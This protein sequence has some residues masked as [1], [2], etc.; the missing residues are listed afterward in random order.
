MKTF[1]DENYKGYEFH[2]RNWNASVGYKHECVAVKDDKEI[3]DTRVVINW[4]NRTWEP[5]QYASVLESCKD[6]LQSILDGHVKPEIDHDFLNKLADHCY[7][8]D[9]G[10]FENGETV[11]LMDYWEQVEGEDEQV[12]D[13]EKR[14]MVKTG[15]FKKSVYAKLC[16]LAE[17]GH[18]KPSVL[19]TIKNVDY[20]FTDQYQR[21]DDCGRIYNYE[22]GELT[23]LEGEGTL[24]CENCMNSSDRVTSLIEEAKEDFRKAL[25]PTVDQSI[26]EGLG[27][28][29]VT[30]ETFSFEKE[31]WG[32]TYMTPT[33]AEDFIH[34]F[35]G[36][37]QI[38]EVAQ[39]VTPFQI[40]VPNENL[41]EA[42]ETIANDFNLEVA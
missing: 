25:K 42:Q 7:I 22:Y 11:I 18:L 9:Y 28:T 24:V 33:Y 40:W 30:D 5:Y 21:C 23:Y 36:F 17:T 34:E 6:R 29:L 10:E 13:E 8:F 15:N 16:E 19:S 2:C 38:Y 4:G 14:Q 35:N 39:F 31:F 27:Y 20:V 32:A 12:W 26:I 37:I 1:T 41:K 3:E